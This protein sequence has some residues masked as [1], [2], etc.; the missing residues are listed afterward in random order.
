MIGSAVSGAT[1]LSIGFIHDLS[2]QS[3][4]VS[5]P[6]AANPPFSLVGLSSLTVAWLANGNPAEA[7]YEARLSTAADFSAVLGSSQTYNLNATFTGLNPNTLYYA[8]AAAYSTAV[9]SW[10]AFAPLGSTYTLAVPPGSPVAVSTFTGWSSNGFTINW[11]SGSALTGYNPAGT[12]YLAEISTSGTFAILWAS[13]ETANLSA[14]FSGLDEYTNYFARVRARNTN[15]VT[16][17][18]TVLGSTFTGAPFVYPGII[19]TIA[20]SGTTSYFTCLGTLASNS[21]MRDLGGVVSD[22]NGNIYFGAY[23]RICKVDPNGIITAFV[24]GGGFG[25]SGDNG[26]AIDAQ[27]AHPG[28]IVFDPSGNMFFSDSSNNRIRKIATNGVITTIAGTGTAGYSGDG[29]QAT[30]AAIRPNGLA[31][32]TSGN[33]YFTDASSRIRK[34]DTSG[35]VTTF[36]GNGGVGYG[37]DGGPSTAATLN[38]PASVA[39][40]KYGNI[41]ISD[42]YNNR[43]RKVDATGRITTIVGSG[44]PGYS[45]DGGTAVN[46]ELY[47]PWGITTDSAGNLYIAERLNQRI[48]KVDVNGTISTIGGDGNQGFGGDGDT[49]TNAHLNSPSNVAAGTPGSL[50]FVDAL[51][52]RVREI[53]VA[54]SAVSTATL[55]GE[56]LSLTAVRWSWNKVARAAA[57]KL[58]T[59]TASVISGAISNRNT[60][61]IETALSTNTL[62]SREL[63]AI[64]S[65]GISTSSV[66]SAYTLADAPSGIAFGGTS[67][68]TVY[69]TWNANTNPASTSFEVSYTTTAGFAAGSTIS[70]A[71]T[72]TSTFTTVA[73]LAG[74][75]TYYFRVRAYNGDSIATAFTTVAATATAV[76]QSSVTALSVSTGTIGVAFTITGTAFGTPNGDTTRVRFGAG[77]STAPITSWSDTQISAVVPMLSSGAYALLIERQGSI[78]TTTD[79]GAF[80]VVTPF[81]STVTPVM[82]SVGFEVV[83]SGFGE[84]VDAATTKVL[85]DDSL[86]VDLSSWTDTMIRCVVSTTTSLGAHTARVVR[87]PSVGTVQSNAYGFDL[88]TGMRGQSLAGAVPWTAM[89]L[90][91]YQGNLR[92]WA[93][94]GKVMA[95]SH[96]SV[97]V[98]PGALTDAT[99]VSIERGASSGVDSDAREKARSISALGVMGAPIEFGPEGTRFAVPVTIELPY[100]LASVPLGRESALAIH[101][102]DRTA[103]AW[104]ALPTEV[105]TVQHLLRARTDHF[106]LYQPLLSGVSPAA[107]APAEFRQVDVYAFPNPARRSQTVTIR[108]QV[109][110]ADDVAIRIYDISGRLVHSGS[111]SSPQIVDDGNGKGSQYTYDYVWDTGG[112]GSGVYLFAITAKKAGS[113]PIQKT[114]K[115][116]VIK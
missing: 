64:N 68:S 88:S 86:T 95:L 32:D 93:G 78:F 17:L 114:G 26:Q 42:Q 84:F 74:Q 57:Y 56:S 107:V 47:W 49:A 116:G 3:V 16:T 92:L 15:N 80:T 110:L 21:N 89:P 67:T 105:D 7:L 2:V 65:A 45:G 27:L 106:S 91:F 98:P 96:A 99:S 76:L 28:G 101:Y 34:I 77:G 30:D 112:A 97:D 20:G 9:S 44:T 13:S 102:W 81:I 85:L 61:F 48:R 40:D 6:I 53:S 10:S 38:Y 70:T 58:L 75:T 29:G 24:G 19:N 11:S 79:A 59:S 39:I 55:V 50:F 52:Y 69:L 41:L 5:S 62:Y 73:S 33:I 72:T 111:V 94:G 87:A 1:D 14:A 108:S 66:V 18:F 83:G 12:Q 100:D 23:S 71:P 54:T 113:S 63:V 43:I 82:N 104:T 109:G 90:W 25:Y 22:A 36:A 4:E 103:G 8:R 51:N 37:G 46:A 60:Y 35:V 31:L 115:V